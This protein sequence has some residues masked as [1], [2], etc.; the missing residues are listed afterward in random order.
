MAQLIP[1]SDAF[2][3]SE[4]AAERKLFPG[5]LIGY[6]HFIVENDRLR[7]PSYPHSWTTGENEAECKGR[8]TYLREHE[9]RLF[10]ASLK[11]S[12]D[13]LTIFHSGETVDPNHFLALDYVTNVMMYHGVHRDTTDFNVYVTFEVP[14][15]ASYDLNLTYINSA[16]RYYE[17]L[18]RTLE[19]PHSLGQCKCGFYA[20]YS[21]SVNFYG[22]FQGLSSSELPMA[23]AVVEFYGSVLL[24]TKGFRATKGR[25][26]AIAPEIDGGPTVMH[27]LSKNYPDAEVYTKDVN[28][29]EAHPEPDRSGLGVRARGDYW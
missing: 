22:G 2:D 3:P 6:R 5:T 19:A 4:T 16:I 28:M 18:I 15:G 27:G 14:G 29:I 1:P 10:L 7:S 24:A 26:V 21:P 23:H 25:I 11:R 20:S 8:P 12:A 9:A 17:D 13:L